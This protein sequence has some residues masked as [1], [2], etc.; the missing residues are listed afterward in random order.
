MTTYAM[1]Y[2]SIITDAKVKNLA[3]LQ[4]A[5]KQKYTGVALLPSDVNLL[6]IKTKDYRLTWPLIG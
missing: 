6:K 5:Y 1:T 4:M 2:D 3:Q